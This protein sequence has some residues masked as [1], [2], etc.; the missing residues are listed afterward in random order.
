VVEHDNTSPH[1]RIKELVKMIRALFKF[2]KIPA[3]AVVILRNQDHK[4]EGNEHG[5]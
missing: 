2:S 1:P 3:L 4:G 5:R